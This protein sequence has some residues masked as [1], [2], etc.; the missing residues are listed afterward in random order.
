MDD[1]VQEVKNV[2][3]KES[4]SQRFPDETAANAELTQKSLQKKF[5]K[6]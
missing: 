3:A 6:F 1:V 2:G 5:Q 4:H